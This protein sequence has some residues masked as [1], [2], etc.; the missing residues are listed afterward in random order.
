MNRQFPQQCLHAG[1]LEVT[2]LGTGRELDRLQAVQ[3]EQRALAS[4]QLGE[5]LSARPGI[6]RGIGHTEPNAQ[7]VIEERLG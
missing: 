1:V 6:E 2:H 7:G 3:D 5:S 4:D